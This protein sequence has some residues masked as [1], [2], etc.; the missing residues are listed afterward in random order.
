MRSLQDN[1]VLAEESQSSREYPR[2]LAGTYADAA[3]Y[4]VDPTAAPGQLRLDLK[5]SIASKPMLQGQTQMESFTEADRDFDGR[6]MSAG[7]VGA[8]VRSSR[9][10]KW[11]PAIAIKPAARTRQ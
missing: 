8:Y 10:P 6:H 1:V 2:N 11:T 7:D 3:T 5:P 9:A 4:L